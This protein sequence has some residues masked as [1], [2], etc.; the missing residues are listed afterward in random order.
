VVLS[1]LNRQKDV[2][3]IRAS[4]LDF[5]DWR[6]QSSSFDAMAGHVGTGFTFSGGLD[7]EFVTGHLVTADFFR[8]LG[9]APVAARTFAADE[10][11]AGRHHVIVIAHG[12]WQRR[13][14][15]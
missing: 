7:P 8:V 10:F 1:S 14:G 9:V 15:G 13:F 2:G 5:A 6:N 12:L 11:T 4:A 3:Q